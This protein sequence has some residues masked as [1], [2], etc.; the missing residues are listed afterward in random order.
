MRVSTFSTCHE[1]SSL[2]SAPHMRGLSL[3]C[4]ISLLFFEGGE[5]GLNCWLTSNV[6]VVVSSGIPV[7]VSIMD[8]P[9]S[10]W[11]VRIDKVWMTR[12]NMIGLFMLWIRARPLSDNYSA[13]FM[14]FPKHR[15]STCLLGVLSQVI[16]TLAT[17]LHAVRW[18]LCNQMSVCFLRLLNCLTIV[19]SVV[20]V[21]FFFFSIDHYF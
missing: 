2:R 13:L 1:A 8:F 18:E 4:W 10:K 17:S 20:G 15:F 16:K 9:N 7:N 19:L 5:V 11:C 14:V 21:F 3:S 6:S 12:L